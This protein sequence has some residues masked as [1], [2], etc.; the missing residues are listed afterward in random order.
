MRF[1]THLND[2]GYVLHR[3]E[4]PPCDTG[5]S[6]VRLQWSPGEENTISAPAWA[7]SMTL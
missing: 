7:I 1:H 6:G 2:G 4:V 5:D 3:I